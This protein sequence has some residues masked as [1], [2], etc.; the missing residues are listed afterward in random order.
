MASGF[1]ITVE[2]LRELQAK[3][4][5]AD[6]AVAKDLKDELK[7]LGDIVRADAQPRAHWT[8]VGPYKTIVKQKEVVVRQSKGKVTGLRGDFGALQMREALEPA[9]AAKSGEIQSGMED[10]CNRL[11]SEAGL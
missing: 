7:K 4:K 8:A 11:V 9:L 2:G 3:L 6:G 5:K 10:M 1:T